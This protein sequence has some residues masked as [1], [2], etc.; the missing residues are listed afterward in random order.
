MMGL[1]I[2]K[3][4]LQCF[5]VFSGERE[6]Q[7]QNVQSASFEMCGYCLFRDVC[8]GAKTNVVMFLILLSVLSPLLFLT[9]SAK[10]LDAYDPSTCR[11]VRVTS[12][13]SFLIIIIYFHC[14][15]R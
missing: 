11:G 4:S 14:R 2:R 12:I 13:F 9:A 6:S 3:F 1:Q 5:P 10:E 7:K 8:E 15:F